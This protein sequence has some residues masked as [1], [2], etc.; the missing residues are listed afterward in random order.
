MAAKICTRRSAT[1]RAGKDRPKYLCAGLR[2]EDSLAAKKRRERSTGSSYAIKCI[3][4]AR[5]LIFIRPQGVEKGA[6][7]KG[8]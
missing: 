6:G 3:E 1:A 7:K 5:L 2:H 8:G 4:H